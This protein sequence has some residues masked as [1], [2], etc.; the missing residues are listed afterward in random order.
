MRR[1]V[2]LQEMANCL[3]IVQWTSSFILILY[4]KLLWHRKAHDGQDDDAEEV[5]DDENG[6][7]DDDDD[8]LQVGLK[9]SPPFHDESR[10]L[11]SDQLLWG[12][13]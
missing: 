3:N 10:L 6:D 1:K 13:E 2:S 7:D 11:A 9:L 4:E 5:G 8:D 12:Q